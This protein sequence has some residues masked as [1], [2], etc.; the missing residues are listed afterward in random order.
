MLQVCLQVYIHIYTYRPME[1]HSY[2]DFI[3]NI[4]IVV[5]CAIGALLKFQID[6]SRTSWMPFCQI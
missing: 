2:D 5:H 4:I 1:L 3:G 6:F